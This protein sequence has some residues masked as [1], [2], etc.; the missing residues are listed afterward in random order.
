MPTNGDKAMTVNPI[1]VPDTQKPVIQRIYG[2]DIN[3]ILS[4]DNFLKFGVFARG[5]KCLIIVVFLRSG[6]EEQIYL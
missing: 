4:H 5:T 1:Y 2:S 6:H 3:K